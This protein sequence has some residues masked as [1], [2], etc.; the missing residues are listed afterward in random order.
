MLGCELPVFPF[1]APKLTTVAS[2]RL[3]KLTEIPCTRSHRK[4][5]ARGL[6]TLLP[7]PSLDSDDD[8][9][10][11]QPVPIKREPLSETVIRERR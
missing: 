11:N 8:D 2:R 3:S 7:A 5:M 1:S 6:I 9:P 10:D 4:M